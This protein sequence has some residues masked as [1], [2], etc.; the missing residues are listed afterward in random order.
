MKKKLL[1]A[2]TAVLFVIGVTSMANL[3]AAQDPYPNCQQDCE[4]LVGIGLFSSHGACMSA[5]H[6]CTPPGGGANSAVC[7]CKIIDAEVGLG[8]YGLNFGQCVTLIK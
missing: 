4:L 5:C 1:T 8:T 7:F 2:V 3:N 6:T